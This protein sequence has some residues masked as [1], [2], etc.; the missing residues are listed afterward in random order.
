M[1]FFNLPTK[2]TYYPSLATFNSS[3]KL[4]ND[5]QPGTQQPRHMR[6]A[7]QKVSTLIKVKTYYWNSRNSDQNQK[8]LEIVTFEHRHL[9]FILFFVLHNLH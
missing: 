6:E 8:F 1:I 3:K 5:L 2:H 7:K 9:S 4:K